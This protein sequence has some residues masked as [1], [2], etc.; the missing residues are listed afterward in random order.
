MTARKQKAERVAILIDAPNLNGQQR[1]LGFAIKHQAL[2][3]TLADGREI[4]VS[5]YYDM[6]PMA[7]PSRNFHGYLKGFL[8]VVLVEP[9]QDV[10][11]MITQDILRFNKETVDTIILVSGDGH[12]AEPL[13]AAKERGCKIEVFSTSTSTAIELNGIGEIVDLGT[14]KDQIIDVEKTRRRQQQQPNG[15]EFSEKL[16]GQLIAADTQITV[17]NRPG[18]IIIRIK[19]QQPPNGI[20]ELSEKLVGQL[21]AADSQI[22]VTNRPGEIIIRIK[23]PREAQ[24][25]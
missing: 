8:E 22:R 5:R 15:T 11:Q 17:A 16:V 25:I 12:F 7:L 14:L 10:D 19:P 1:E 20:S 3:T 2:I 13:I 9:G 23:L 4:V 6:R 21:I 24:R 18:E